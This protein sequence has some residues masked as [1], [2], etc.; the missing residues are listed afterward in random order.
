[1]SN[2]LL[3]LH[4]PQTMGHWTVFQVTKW[5]DTKT[6]TIV[7]LSNDWNYVF[8]PGNMPRWAVFLTSAE[9][10]NS[11]HNLSLQIVLETLEFRIILCKQQKIS[12]G[13]GSAFLEMSSVAGW[14][15]RIR[16]RR[17]SMLLNLLNYFDQ[18]WGGR[19]LVQYHWLLQFIIQKM[20]H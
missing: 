2:A 15:T 1:M 13:G 7:Y 9:S 8:C 14:D 6:I 18:H 10:K 4:W 11:R 12:L 5:K 19:F 3:Y 20:I 16:L 17:F